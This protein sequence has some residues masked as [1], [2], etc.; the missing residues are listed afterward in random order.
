MRVTTSNASFAFSGKLYLFSEGLTSSIKSLTITS[1]QW[2]LEMG[3]D[4]QWTDFGEGSLSKAYLTSFSMTYNGSKFSISNISLNALTEFS[5]TSDLAFD[6]AFLQRMLSSAD[7]ISGG[8]GN[9]WLAGYAGKDTLNGGAGADTADYS[10]KTTSVIVTLNKSTNAKVYV[11]GTAEDT[12]KNIEN[13]T[14][15][16]GNDQFTGDSMANTLKGNSG[17][18]ILDGSSGTD[19]LIGDAGNDTYVVDLY[20]KTSTTL[21]LQD[22]IIEAASAGT[23]TLKL[24]LSSDQKL[25]VQTFT[26]AAN[27]ENMDA[28]LTSTNKI[29]LTGNSAA[30]TLTGNAGD[31]VI[32]GGADTV[33]DIIDGGA[34]TD[35]I[36]FASILGSTGVTFALGTYN[37]TTKA[38]DQTVAKIGATSTD[39]AS[40]VENITGSKNGDVL[41][42]NDANNLISGVTGA[43]TLTGGK[44][45][46]NLYGGSN[47]GVKDIFD[48]NAVTESGTGTT[49][50]KVYDFV[51]NIDKIDLSGIDANTATA[52]AG[53]QAFLFNSTT[54]KANSVWYKVADV[55]G[56]TATTDIIVYGDVNGDGKADFEIGLVGVASLTS[57]DFVL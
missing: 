28:S 29:N 23:D 44:G 50:D 47:D 49:R 39:K 7:S 52:K 26:L 35:T 56:N 45:Q 54:A 19:L 57:A 5:S 22:T 10:E 11:N 33:A 51:T 9:D 6:E 20:N 13:L 18:D 37:A 1:P 27:L 21:A 30:N 4:F 2:S 24:R 46:D 55:D 14:G 53:D 8:A 40:N 42:G 17:D 36:S 15:G 41:T 43:D 34:G 16:S 3:G 38:T 48:F 31:N 25:A 32:D 12:I